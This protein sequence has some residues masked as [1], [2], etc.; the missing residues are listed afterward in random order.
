MPSDLAS[1]QLARPHISMQPSLSPAKH[2]WL[3]SGAAPRVLICLQIACQFILL[4]GAGSASA[5]R[6]LVRISTFATSLLFFVVRP[7]AR[8]SVP[9][10]PAKFCLAAVAIVGLSILHPLT[11]SWLAGLA[12]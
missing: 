12:Q 3:T 8:R 4:S 7:R 10:P 6:P 2:S 1:S 11:S 5:L 9:P